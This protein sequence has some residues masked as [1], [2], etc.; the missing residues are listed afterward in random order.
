MWRSNKID[1]L[2]DYCKIKK[3]KSLG[4]ADSFNLCGALEFSEKLSKVGTHP[5]IGTQ[6]NLNFNNTVGKITL[7]AKT[8]LGY[9]N[10]TKLSSLIYL[11]SKN[12]EEPSCELEDLRHNNK[13]LILLTGNY[14]DYFGK[15]FQSNKLSKFTE[16]AS[17]LKEIFHDRM[18]FEIQRHNENDENFEHFILKSSKFLNIPLIATQGVYYLNQ[19]M[20]EAHDA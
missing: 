4:L 9:K 10:L 2:V 5:I 12:T 18:Y 20:Y 13:D 3:I 8:E 6:I 15:L 17:D 16:T 7:Y 1:D 14:R 19:D 11:N